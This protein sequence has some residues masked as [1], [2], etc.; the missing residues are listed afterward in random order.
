VAAT[1]IRSTATPLWGVPAP[2]R[3][4]GWRR[5]LP[6]AI[7]LAALGL[8]PLLRFWPL[9]APNPRDQM[10]LVEGDFNIEFFPQIHAI[11]TIV[12]GGE[13]PLWNPWS[14]AGQPLMADPQMA[15]WYPLNWVLPWL[16]RDIGASS[17]VALEAHTVL[18]LGLL[19][20][21]TYLLG[22]AVIG[23]RLGAL[24]AA[25]VFAFSGLMTSYPVQQVPIMRCAVWFPLLLLC[26]IR[27]LDR[28]SL[29]WALAGGLALAL[30]ILAGHPQLL[31]FQLYGLALYGGYRLWELRR[32]PRAVVHAT[33]LG[34]VMGIVGLS[35][36][37]IQLV[38]SLEFLQLSDRATSSYQFTAD[39]F[40]PFELVLDSLAPRILGGVP[41]YVGILPL[42]LAATAV[43]GV[44]HRLVPYFALLG[45][46]GLVVSLGGH[47][48]VH[49]VLYLFAPGFA[50]FQ[51]Q[52]RAIYLYVCAVALLA[53]YGAAW[54]E[55]PLSQTARRRL[56]LVG[57]VVVAGLIAALVVAAVL[58]AGWLLVEGTPRAARWRAA[59]DWWNWF[60]L[61]LA[62]ALAL[63]ALRLGWRHGRGLLRVAGP[64]LIGLDLFTV[65]WG[66]NLA[67][68]PPDQVFVPSE[69]V[70]WLQAVREPYRLDDRGVLNGNS[71]LVYL[72][73]SVDG[74]YG[75]FVARFS[76]LKTVLP[77]HELWK[78]LNVRFV[79]TREPPWPGV[80]VAIEEPYLEHTNRVFVLHDVLPRV[81]VVPR[82]RV[83]SDAEALALLRAGQLDLRQEVLLAE[84]PPLGPPEGGG[85]AHVVRYGATQ[86]EVAVDTAGGYLLLS[87]IYFPGWRAEVD[88]APR[89][90]LR[91]NYGLRAVP[92][93]PGDRLVRLE[94]AP[95][96]LRW[97]AAITLAALALVGLLFAL[98]PRL[99][100]RRLAGRAAQA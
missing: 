10:T 15:I 23:S 30:A 68:R 52:E 17:L 9:F 5:W 27:A 7:L 86:L 25:L 71:G 22:R 39:G 54:F 53:G 94:Y 40:S 51:H 24:A 14:D 66:V 58:Y 74:A 60:V 72:L 55:Q 4:P 63:L 84:A 96:S 89:P 62:A 69:I 98:A 49:S 78:L 16:V 92:L 42:L 88:G 81:L 21:T 44:R 18:Q 31:L 48:F 87:E 79:V 34:A 32:A 64:L 47:S 77:P 28:F 82:G 45:A 97:G 76:M 65:G 95:D 43:G 41:L 73:P 50:L 35:V 26:L 56:L 46:L 99:E 83:V 37:A 75:M 61:M 33:L 3:M 6:D 12:R 80:E 29:R 1:A 19:A 20:I 90:L 67:P 91:A 13:L 38:P 11:S 93:Q 57:R 100:A 70:R 36:A 8:L 85:Q 2:A 59:I